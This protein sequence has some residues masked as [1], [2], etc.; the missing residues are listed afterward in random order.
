MNIHNKVTV[1]V[2]AVLSSTW[3]ANRWKNLNETFRVCCAELKL[4]IIRLLNGALQIFRCLSMR[5]QRPLTGGGLTQETLWWNMEVVL[6][7]GGGYRWRTI[8]SAS[9][10]GERTLHQQVL[11]QRHLSQRVRLQGQ[12]KEN[13]VTT[14]WTCWRG[15]R[16]DEARERRGGGLFTALE[17]RCLMRW[18]LLLFIKGLNSEM[19][20]S[21]I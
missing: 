4:Q 7:R 15:P 12:E 11:V 13:N 20:F 5:I 9:R 6:S 2:T 18:R 14:S 17:K 16:R 10:P 8:C 19:L 3:A 21:Y 1:T